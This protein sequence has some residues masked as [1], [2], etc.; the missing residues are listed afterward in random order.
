[1]HFKIKKSDLLWALSLVLPAVEKRS[2]MPI[3]QNVLLRTD[4]KDALLIAGTNL[5]MSVTAT[6]HSVGDI[7]EPG[8]ITVVAATLLTSIKGQPG[9]EIEVYTEEGHKVVLKTAMSKHTL[10]GL[11]ARDFPRLPTVTGL[12]LREVDSAPIIA[13]MK[14]VRHA[15]CTDMTREA[16][17]S[18]YLEPVGKKIRAVS[19]NGHRMA[20]F[21]IS[22]ELPS[23]VLIPT[24]AIQ[25]VLTALEQAAKVQI[26]KKAD[27][28]FI[29]A[30]G[31]T[32][33]VRLS[34]ASFPPF[35]QVIPKSWTIVST[36]EKASAL[37]A[38]CS[39]IEP[40][41]SAKTHRSDVSLGKKRILIKYENPD[42]GSGE[43]M[44]STLDHEGEDL[45]MGLN[46]TYLKQAL[47][48]VGDA[49]VKLCCNGDLDPILIKSGDF[50]GV[51]MP[52]RP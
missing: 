52:M 44:I 3:L 7:K 2:S 31:V 20:K 13:A 48:E 43:E 15:V 19:T 5:N 10:H 22:G 34:S 1:M 28:L 39:R 14:T 35:D 25:T 40:S 11:N 24:T 38:A 4:G 23:E 37:A 51:V 50:M 12:D 9:D 42:I 30:D 47:A 45:A 41:T 6:V 46:I 32:T 18:L 33:M 36:I 8:D 49:E 29:V 21:E 27:S 17:A 26:A 16:L